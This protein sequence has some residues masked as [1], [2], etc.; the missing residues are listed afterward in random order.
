[1]SSQNVQMLEHRAERR[2]RLSPQEAVSLVCV[3]AA[4]PRPDESF[5][6]KGNKSAAL[7]LRASNIPTGVRLQQFRRQRCLSL[8]ALAS[9][10]GV[11]APTVWAWENGKCRPQARRI[12]AIAAVLDVDPSELSDV[13]VREDDVSAVIDDCRRRIAA[14][15]GTDSAAVRIT[16]EV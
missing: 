8:S 13:M 6:T 10:L 5:E 4:H 2:R 11:S 14:V 9:A 15:C 1:M 7:M 3:D 16:V 12:A